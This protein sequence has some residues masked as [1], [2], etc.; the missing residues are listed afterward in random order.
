MGGDVEGG[1]SPMKA[2]AMMTAPPAATKKNFARR[3]LP[4]PLEFFLC[5]DPASRFVVRLFHMPIQIVITQPI[6]ALSR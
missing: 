5:G 6:S 4:S 2:Q 3:A 1:R